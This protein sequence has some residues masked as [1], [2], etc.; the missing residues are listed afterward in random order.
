MNR[1]KRRS[2]LIALTGVILGA[3]ASAQELNIRRVETFRVKPDRTADF[4]TQI[5]EYVNV[6]KKANASHAIG[7]WS[8]LTGPN[9]FFRVDNYAKY[10]ELDDT[11]D[12]KLKEVRSDLTSIGIRITD[13]TESAERVYYRVRSD[14]SLPPPQETPKMLTVLRVKVQP[15]KMAEYISMKKEYIALAKK[16]GGKYH[17]VMQARFG[18][19]EWEFLTVEGIDKWSDLD[20]PSP[21]AKAIGAEASRKFTFS[22]FQ[23]ER[24]YD[25]VRFRF[26]LS[27]IPATSTR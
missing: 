6:L 12:P 26:E 14:L 7:M 22:L 11:Q 15:D 8:S 23:T 4:Q 16:V 27:Y 5:K 9:E 1:N 25:I 17:E 20:G 3:S 10:G 13:C 21:I 18:A 2:V 19:S 24:Q